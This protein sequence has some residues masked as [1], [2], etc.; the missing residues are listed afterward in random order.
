MVLTFNDYDMI[1]HNS[2]LHTQ[3]EGERQTDR[4]TDTDT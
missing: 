4:Q 1:L 2:V 3:T